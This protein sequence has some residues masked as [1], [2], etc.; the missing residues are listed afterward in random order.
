M[1]NRDSKELLATPH[2]LI[3]ASGVSLHYESARE[4]FS[5][6]LGVLKV[7]QWEQGH[8]QRSFRRRG[9]GRPLYV[10]E[11]CGKRLALFF[12][13]RIA[14]TFCECWRYSSR[15][16]GFLSAIPGGAVQAGVGQAG[17]D[18]CRVGRPLAWDLSA[19]WLIIYCVAAVDGG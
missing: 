19:H 4:L 17:R 11:L 12:K 9:S 14:V 1:Q 18:W 10:V 3:S 2:R 16:W 6:I 15:R 13:I 8:P 7:K 5:L